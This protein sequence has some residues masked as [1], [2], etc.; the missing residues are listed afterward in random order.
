MS[1]QGQLISRWAECE[2]QI[3]I[4]I[5]Q[6]NWRVG[7]FSSTEFRQQHSAVFIWS[8][9]VIGTM[10]HKVSNG[11]ALEDHFSVE[12]ILFGQDQQ[13]KPRRTFATRQ[14]SLPGQIATAKNQ[15]WQNVF[16]FGNPT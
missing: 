16:V 8:R 2:K 4:E 10:R 3:E 15:M 7:V 13:S 14:P 1:Q 11:A 12:N 6:P 5:E 9:P